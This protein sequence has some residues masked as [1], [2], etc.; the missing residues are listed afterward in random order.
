MPTLEE[1]LLGRIDLN[2]LGK[3]TSLS[4]DFAVQKSQSSAALSP[5]SISADNSENRDNARESTSLPSL[6]KSLGVDSPKKAKSPRSKSRKKITID[7][8]KIDGTTKKEVRI[9]DSPRKEREVKIDSPRKEK[10]DKIDSPRKEKSDKPDSPK[11]SKS[12]NKLDSPRTSAKTDSPRDSK[13]DNKTDS[14]RKADSGTVAANNS[15]SSLRKDEF[16]E[17]STVLAGAAEFERNEAADSSED[18]AALKRS[19]K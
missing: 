15:S 6:T 4:A 19:S 11:N 16:K 10:D 12:D 1:Q 2:Q 7:T 9:L 13:T 8:E 5:R 3:G 17:Y 18:E 14:P